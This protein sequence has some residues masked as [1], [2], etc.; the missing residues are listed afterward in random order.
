[1]TIALLQPFFQKGR[2]PAPIVAPAELRKMLII[3]PEKLGDMVITLPLVQ[4][5][6]DQ[7]PGITIDLLASPKGLAVVENDP[8]F[9]NIWLYRKHWLKDLRTI[10]EIR[11]ES[12]DLVIEMIDDDSSTGLLLSQWCSGSAIRIGANKRKNASWYDAS[13]DFHGNP[14]VHAIDR[15]LA[16]LPLL[17]LTTDGVEAYVPPYVPD[18]AHTKAAAFLRAPQ[19]GK[20]DHPCLAFN[21]SGGKATRQWDSASAVTTITEIQRQISDVRIILIC[22]PHEHQR[23]ESLLQQINSA[24]LVPADWSILDIT[25]LLSSMHLLVSP[26]TSLV[27]IARSFK[28]PVV[29]LY[30]SLEETVRRWAPYGQTEGI[31]RSD[32]PGDIKGIAPEKISAEVVSMLSRQKVGRP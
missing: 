10:R 25:A 32:D 24:A 5:I 30:P 14:E 21:I 27:H 20:S 8:R 23:G 9:R 1:M 2:R 31:I 28:I 19:D 12:Y 3:K 17:G 26:D 7:A 11:A 18:Q 16:I 4:A 15:A 13:T 6:R 22:A 29:G